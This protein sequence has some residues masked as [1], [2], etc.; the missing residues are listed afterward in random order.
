[1]DPRVHIHSGSSLAK[2]YIPAEADRITQL[3]IDTLKDINYLTLSY[4][5]GTTR[6][7]DSIYTVHLTTPE[8]I[9][10]L[11]KGHSASDE[12]HTGQHLADMLKAALGPIGL[13]NVAAICCDSTGNT[14][15]CREILSREVPTILAL[16]DV[17]HYLNNTAKDIGKLEYFQSVRHTPFCLH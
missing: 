7:L 5:G 8:R 17:C 11:L 1:M 2:T 6:A 10:H 9:S 3:S 15:L 13:A 4:D 16:G 12:S 14:R